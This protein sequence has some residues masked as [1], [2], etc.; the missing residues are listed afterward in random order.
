MTLQ[1]IGQ[2]LTLRQ[3]LLLPHIPK[4]RVS[5]WNP[6]SFPSPESHHHSLSDFEWDEPSSMTHSPIPQYHPHLLDDPELIAGKHRTLLTFTSYMVSKWKDFWVDRDVRFNCA[7]ADFGHRLCEAGR[8]EERTERQV[9]RE[10]P[11]DKAHVKQTAVAEARDEEN[12]QGGE[13]DG[14][15]RGGSIVRLLRKAHPTEPDQQ[16]EPKALRRRVPPFVSQTERRQGRELEIHYRGKRMWNRLIGNPSFRVKSPQRTENI[17]RLNRKELIA[18]EFAVLVA[19]EF[20][21]HVPTWEVL[22]H[23][24]RLLYEFWRLLRYDLPVV[25]DAAESPT[26]NE[27]PN[28]RCH[29]SFRLSGVA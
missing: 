28:P 26:L 11:R 15:G 3:R 20:G 2:A 23:Y 17:F 9:Q 25:Q 8:P 22:P 27:L 16:G 18:S 12:R 6:Y 1:P 24:Q 13:R 5:T 14:F 29:P 4:R 21:L 10:I 7:F 19:L